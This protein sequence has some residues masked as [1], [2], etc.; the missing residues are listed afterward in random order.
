[1]RVGDDVVNSAAP[2][3]LRQV[4]NVAIEVDIA[5]AELASDGVDERGCG[6]RRCIRRVIIKLTQLLTIRD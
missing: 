4:G 6:V 2:D 3:Q 1:M 5:E